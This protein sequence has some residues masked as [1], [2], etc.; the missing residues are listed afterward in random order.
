MR[1]FMNSVCRW[2]SEILFYVSIRC[3]CTYYSIETP[4]SICLYYISIKCT[5]P[6]V[7]H[8]GN[9]LTDFKRPHVL[10]HLNIYSLVQVSILILHNNSLRV[11]FDI[12]FALD[13]KFYFS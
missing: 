9:I 6:T 13:V 7:R 3:T 12:L 4:Q 8:I 5:Q 1:Q 2:V 10:L 11:C